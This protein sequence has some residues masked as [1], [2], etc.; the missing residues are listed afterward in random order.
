MSEIPMKSRPTRKAI[1]KPT[2]EEMHELFQS[3]EEVADDDRNFK[4]FV[5][6]SLNELSEKVGIIEQNAFATTATLK[7]H[8]DDS[9]T[10]HTLYLAAYPAE[11]IDGHRR[12]H[13]SVIE[14]RELRNKMVREAML[15]CAGAT[16]LTAFGWLLYAVWVT[17]KMEIHK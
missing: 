12:Y 6:R 2:I 5:I 4:L 9:E 8:M 10:R 17:V 11:D 16:G 7:R 15:K 1:M 14:W 13:E 3:G